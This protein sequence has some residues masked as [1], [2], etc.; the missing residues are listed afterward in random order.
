[1]PDEASL[2]ADLRSLGCGRASTLLVH[3]SLRSVGPVRGGARTVVRAL[4]SALGSDGTLA[5]PTFTPGNSLTSRTYLART[6]DMS[7][8]RL[9]EFQDGM[10]PFEA[11]STPSEGMGAIAEHVRT[12]EGA[13]RSV[14]PQTSFAAL[15]PRAT[16]ITAH[17]ARDCLLGER[18]P[19][20]RLYECGAD[21]LLLGVGFEVCSAFHLAEYRVSA[22]TRRYDCKVMGRSA[23]CWTSFV[24]VDLDDS[25]FGELGLWL[26]TLT[27]DG[28][29]PIARGRVG[30]ADSRLVPLR[31]AVDAA[32]TWMVSGRNR[33]GIAAGK[34]DRA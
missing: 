10:E 21:I 19:L 29:S 30:A 15:G 31:W 14:H 7:E 27:S 12:A 23:P 3:A 22:P 13:A 6:Q 11:A 1:M 25:D 17:H 16:R 2:E 28:R 5:V 33:P 9:A 20:G 8:R 4:R 32:V 24:D 34:A 18:S 26:E